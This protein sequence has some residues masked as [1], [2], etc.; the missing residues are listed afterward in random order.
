MFFVDRQKCLKSAVVIENLCLHYITKV[1]AC[2]QELIEGTEKTTHFIKLSAPWNVLVHFA[3]ELCMRAPLQAH[4]NPTT[5]WS[6]KILRT[7]HIRNI[8]HENV[9]NKPLDYYTCAFKKSK[10]DKFL[11]S[12]RRDEYFTTNQR[13]RVLW[14][15]LQTTVYGKRRRGQIGIDRM[16]EEGVFAAAFPLHDVSSLYTTSK[17]FPITYLHRGIVQGPYQLPSNP[18]TPQSLNSR[19]ILYL[20]WA[21]WSKW[22]KYQPLDHIREYF[23]EKI[24][25]YFAWLGF[26]TGWLLPAA[27]VGL[28]VFVYGLLTLEGDTPTKEICQEGRHYRMCPVCEEEYN[29]TYWKLS[30]TCVFS[31]LSYLCDQPGTVFFSIF[32]SFWAVTF[33]EHWKKKSASLAHHW[34]CLDYEEDMVVMGIFLVAVVVYRMLVSIPLV[35][36]GGGAAPLV[37]SFSGALINL[38]IITFMGP[39]YERLALRLTEWEMHRTQTEFENN[40]TFKVFIFQFVNYYSSIFYIAFF[41]GK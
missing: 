33:L 22:Y 11:G 7:L 26:Y 18:V 14:Q 19:Q 9:P 1:S 15:I 13:I 35:Q 36:V 24:A 16:L 27:L 17:L 8:L 2:V 37:A 10:V 21:K 28:L 3:E 23:G 31:R 25:I 30:D 34:D 32:V 39:V 29:C 38:L 40:L 12:D 4:P 6:E 5:N 41:K 20:Y